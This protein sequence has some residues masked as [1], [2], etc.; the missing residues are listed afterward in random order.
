MCSILIAALVTSASV[1]PLVSWGGG[2]PAF[3][4]SVYAQI[5]SLLGPLHS[6]VP[7]CSPLVSDLG[8]SHPLW[9]EK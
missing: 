4:F 7:S 3:L 5:H 6:P 1:S 9:W 8:V 2:W